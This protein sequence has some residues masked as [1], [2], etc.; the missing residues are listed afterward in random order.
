MGEKG[1]HKLI[2]F[3]IAAI[4]IGAIA[5]VVMHI[6]PLLEEEQI[7]W[8]LTLVG[9]GGETKVLTFDELK[10]MPSY[11]GYGGFFTTVG[12]KNGPFKCK[13]VPVENLCNLVGGIGSSNTI[14]VYAPDGYLMV[15]TYDQLKGDFI[16]YDPETLREVPHGDLKVIVMYEQNGAPLSEDDG[17]PLRLAIISKDKLM[18]EGHYWVKWLYRIEV[19]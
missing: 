13:G 5:A 1:K 2:I 15:F 10:E 11:E 3:A 18:V 9:K 4:C 17:K 8:N 12:M 16:T 14:W 19:K 6:N 7:N